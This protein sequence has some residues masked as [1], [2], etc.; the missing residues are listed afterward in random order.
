MLGHRS[1]PEFIADEL[2]AEILQGTIVG[3]TQLKQSDIAAR[4]GA[5]IV[6]VREAFQRLIGDGLAV[7]KHNRGVTV[8]EVSEADFVDIA[9]MRALLEPHA[10]ELSAPNLSETDFSEALSALKRSANSSDLLE[11]A[12]LH[13]EFHRI[14]YAKCGR[15]RV[16]AQIG[17]LH[18]SINRYLLPMWSHYGLSDHWDQ[19]H[20]EIVAAIRS[21]SI[22]AAKK[23]VVEQIHESQQRILNAMARSKA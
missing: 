21:G 20:E 1:A 2:R 19:S 13:W 10:L 4:F 9:E 5:S 8:T 15:P 17:N 14:L 12:A 16:V 22:A 18:L 7:A 23:I 3:G 11:R 6:P